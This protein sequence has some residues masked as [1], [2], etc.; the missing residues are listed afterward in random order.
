MDTQRIPLFP[1]GVVLFP[2][3]ALPLHIFEPRYK[4]MIARCIGRREEFGVVLVRGESAREGEEEQSSAIASVGCTAEIVK[5]V[6]RYEDG[7]MDILTMGQTAFRLKHLYEDEPFFEGDVEF[8]DDD[9]RG[10]APE[11]QR[12]LLHAY[13]RCYVLIH[14]RAS[15]QPETTSGAS[16]AFHLA[17]GLPLELDA[18]QELL[19]TRSEAERQEQ[20]LEELEAWLPELEHIQRV[21]GR[22]GGNGHGL[23]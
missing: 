15:A 14:G 6:K 19:E 2:G 4:Q 9:A 13:E 7:R 8:L 16:L 5:V 11:I 18:K 23:N 3:A 21:R 17:G 12:K 1:L 20:L 10:A 22:A